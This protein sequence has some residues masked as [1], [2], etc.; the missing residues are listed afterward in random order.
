MNRH[1]THNRSKAYQENFRK[2]LTLA[3][4]GPTF[5]AQYQTDK[6]TQWFANTVTQPLTILDFGCSDGV[7]TSFI[8][9][10]FSH[11]TVYG[12]DT[13][14]EHIEVARMA[15]PEITFEVT[16]TTLPF[17]DAHFDMIIGADTLHHIPVAQHAHTVAELMR[18]LKTGGICCILEP[19]PYNLVTRYRFNHDPLEE[20]TQM[21]RPRALTALL[22]PYGAPLTFLS[23]SAPP[24]TRITPL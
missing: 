2:N 4:A 3:G 14:T 7:M 1:V 5:F 22:Q 9:T 18:V 10:L 23:F 12:V 15:Y 19:N 16:G 6:L 11:A 24:T 21:I 8:A 17:P 13:S 20:T